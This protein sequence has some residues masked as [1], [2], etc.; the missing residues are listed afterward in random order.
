MCGIAGIWKGEGRLEE[1][2]LEAML[3]RLRR[4]GPD[5]QGMWLNDERSLGLGHRRLNIMEPGPAAHQPA[6]WGGSQRAFCY[7][8]EIYN[9]QELRHCLQGLGHRFQGLGDAEVVA[10]AL[11]QWGVEE[12]LQRFD[13]MFALACWDGTSQRLWLARD[14]LGEKPLFYGRSGGDFFF[15]S[16]VEAIR[17]S[18]GFETRLSRAA[19]ALYLRFGCVPAPHSMVENLWCL[20]AGHLLEVSPGQTRLRPYWK[21]EQAFAGPCPQQPT[22]E[23]HR[24]LQE[25]VRQRLLAAVPVGVLLSGGIDSSLMAA[26]AQSQSSRPLKTFTIGFSRAPLD[27][28]PFSRAVAA[29]LGTEHHE[30]YLSE[31]DALEVVEQLPEMYDQPFADSSQIATHWVS[32][33]A[34]AQVGVVLTGDGGDELFLG[35]GRYRLTL[36]KWQARHGTTLEGLF[37]NQTTLGFLDPAAWLTWQPAS[38]ADY[39]RAPQQPVLEPAKLLSYWDLWHYLPHDILTKV[40]RASM[41]CGLEGRAPF[42]ARPLVELA[43]RLPVRD[44]SEKGLL[45]DILAEYLPR[46]LF[47]R[48]K[49]GFEVPLGDWLRGPLKSWACDLLSAERLRQQGWFRPEPV[50]KLWQEFMDGCAHHHQLWTLLMFQQWLAAGRLA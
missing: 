26:L 11:Q 48:P 15:A 50:Q 24:L 21:L 4:R 23:V 44:V 16:E 1:L 33:M 39:Y 45:K 10:A 22:E 36:N 38:D 30:H 13:G 6:H 34:R 8:G 17:R 41:A 5:G 9:H 12:C 42:L 7:N 27:E 35:Y 40:D 37:L 47:E 19:L 14:R 18:G 28:A 46:P 25:S 29:H 49:Q 31:A 43:C 20:P 3:E 2:Q 32:R